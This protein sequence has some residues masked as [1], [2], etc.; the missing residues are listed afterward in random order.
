MT[1]LGSSFMT[2]RRCRLIYASVI[3][4]LGSNRCLA[5]PAPKHPI[6]S[7]YSTTQLWKPRRFSPCQRNT[8]IARCLGGPC[9]SVQPWGLRLRPSY[10]TCLNRRYLCNHA[11]L[12]VEKS[13]CRRGAWE[14]MRTIMCR[15]SP[16][17]GAFEAHDV[18]S[19]L[20]PPI[21]YSIL[22]ISR[23]GVGVKSCGPLKRWSP[24]AIVQYPLGLPSRP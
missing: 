7:F 6:S 17:S 5:L 23:G 14:W 3:Q 4:W 10:N 16:E 19:R 1:K 8:F 2:Q 12:L 18:I 13:E 22:V 9:G 21:T 24:W 20:F 15:P 11:L